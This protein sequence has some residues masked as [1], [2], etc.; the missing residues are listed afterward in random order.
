MGYSIRGWGK[1]GTHVSLLSVAVLC[2][3]LR[4]HQ[5]ANR[6]CGRQGSGPRGLE[7]QLHAVRPGSAPQDAPP[8]HPPS[9]IHRPGLP[10]CC[11]AAVQFHASSRRSTPGSPSR[12]SAPR[13]PWGP[14]WS[15]WNPL[16]WFPLNQAGPVHA[17]PEDAARFLTRE[18]PGPEDGSPLGSRRVS[19]SS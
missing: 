17:R 6:Q 5:V 9:H 2:N 7:H 13:R 8:D 19:L 16:R 15:P 12:P 4:G 11:S 3:R 14:G 1:P 10:Y 18:A